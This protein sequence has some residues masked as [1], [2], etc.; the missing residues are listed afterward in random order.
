[1]RLEKLASNLVLALVPLSKVPHRLLRFSNGSALCNNKNILSLSG[2][3]F[4]ISEIIHAQP[5]MIMGLKFKRTFTLHTLSH[6]P[7][8]IIYECE[9]C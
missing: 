2:M 9:M 4:Q 6:T 1:M 5:K 7:A 3:K 8:L